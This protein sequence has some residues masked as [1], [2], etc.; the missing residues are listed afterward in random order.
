MNRDSYQEFTRRLVESLSNHQDVIGLVAVGSMAAQDHL[1]DEWS[2]HD[3]FVIVE[4]G[5]QE[6]FRTQLHWLPEHQEIIFSYRETA[7]G[8]KVLYRNAHLLEFAVFDLAELSLARINRF[9]ILLDRNALEPQLTGLQQ[10]SLEESKPADKEWLLGQML[11]NLLVGVGRDRRGEKLSAHMFVKSN[12]VRHLAL[13]FHCCLDS[14][15]KNL[16][17]N[18]D[19]A[20]RIEFVF[21]LQTAEINRALLLP[22]SE[23]ASALLRIAE[24]HLRPHIVNWPEKAIL[25]IK[26]F[27]G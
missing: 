15:Q 9:R 17:D 4:T 26:T 21:P 8:V 5:R 7:H 25:T 13:L 23:A 1:P 12:A 14:P 22:T 10:Q 18:L 24:A 20:R 3:F 19:P 6:S 27:I 16:L 11:S 2:D